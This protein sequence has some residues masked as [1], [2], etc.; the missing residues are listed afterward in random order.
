MNKPKVIIF[1]YFLNPKYNF[2]QNI[3]DWYES[4]KKNYLIDCD[5]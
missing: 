1:N 2:T 3:V 4:M 5:R